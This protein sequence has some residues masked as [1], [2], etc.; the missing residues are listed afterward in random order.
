M[1]VSFMAKNIGPFKEKVGITTLSDLTKKE[2]LE[3]LTFSIEDKRY[4]KISYMFGANGSGKTNYF[5]ALTKMQKIIVLSTVLGAN[6]SKLLEVPAIKKE[7]AS[8]IEP[9]KFDVSAQTIPSEFEIEIVL[10]KTLYRYSFKI[11]DGEI[12]EEYLS[13]KLKRTEYL[14]QRTSPKYEDINLRSDLSSFKSNISVVR[15]DALCL[16]MAAMLNNEIAGKILDEIMNFQIINMTALK[17]IPFLDEDN[18]RLEDIQRYLRYLKIADPTLNDLKIDVESK[19]DRHPIS[20]DDFENK[21]FIIKNIEVDVQAIHSKFDNHKKVADIQ[22]PF[23][24]YESNGTIKLLGILPS[25]FKVLDKGGALFIDEVENGLHPNLVKIITNLFNSPATNPNNAQLIC[26]THNTLLL[27]AV[28][29]DQV[30]FA[31]KDQYGESK[32]Y[33]LSEFRNLRANDNIIQKYLNGAFGAI[34]IM[35]ES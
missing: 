5:I 33:R 1:F 7:L 16:A 24:K 26:T 22:L 3:E 13:K 35:E 27:R 15:K 19:A 9:F 20:E 10:N 11:K 18:S 8:P 30:W 17:E 14:I 23:F 2:M 34:P 25:I 29:R 6:N 31:S 32:I 4:N 21:E 28:R 12:L